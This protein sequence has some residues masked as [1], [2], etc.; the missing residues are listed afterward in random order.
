MTEQSSTHQ[1]GSGAARQFG[2]L[3]SL[4]LTLNKFH[5]ALIFGLAGLYFLLIAYWIIMIWGKWAYDDPFITYRYTNNLLRGI[6]FVYNPGERVLSTTTPFYTLLLAALSPFWGNLPRIANLVGALSIAAGSL[7]IF[8]IARSLKSPI[9]GWVGLL[10]YPSFTLLLNTIG[11]ETPLYIAFALASFAFYYRQNFVFTAAFCALT[12]ITRPD[13]ALVPMIIGVDYL[14]RLWVIRH[15]RQIIPLQPGDHGSDELPPASSAGFRSSSKLLPAI[16]LFFTLTIPWF[17]FAWVYFG[18]PIPATLAAKQHQGLMDISREF[19]AGL[20]WTF[21][22]HLNSWHH[23]LQVGL[24]LI[25]VCQ[26]FLHRRAMTWIVFMAWPFSYFTAYSILG[27]TS[28][29]WYYAPLI[30]GL[31]IL[32]GLGI[33]AIYQLM[34]RGV[35]ALLSLAESK[36]NRFAIAVNE[37]TPAVPDK[38]ASLSAAIII[39]T[40]ALFQAFNM[41]SAASAA[42]PRSMIYRKAGLW[43][44]RNTPIDAKVGTLEVG[45]IGYYSNRPIVDFAGLI[46]PEVANYLNHG[47]T[48]EDF[49]PLFDPKVSTKLSCII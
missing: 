1:T 48:Y 9:V 18:S 5:P 41:I 38:I 39:I 10:L 31:V 28:Y 27:L 32:I 23:W 25:G 7:L 13:G 45:I 40:L 49:C 11:S 43:L 26:L 36:G 19:P 12:V 4:K 30:P 20:L 6:G 29:F 16:L 14:V 22:Q 2:G 42:N 8:D 44:S 47:T 33:S 3:S 35:S 37:R 17:L 24:A 15:Q 21:K 34:R 46:Q